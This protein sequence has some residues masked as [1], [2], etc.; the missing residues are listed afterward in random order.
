MNC[1]LLFAAGPEPNLLPGPEPHKFP[2]H[3]HV[4]YD[5]VVTYSITTP[6]NEQVSREVKDIKYAL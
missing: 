1:M 2:W 5:L 6:I 4:N 3:R